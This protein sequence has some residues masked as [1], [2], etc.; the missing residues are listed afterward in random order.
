MTSTACCR[1]LYFI[2]SERNKNIIDVLGILPRIIIFSLLVRRKIIL[3]SVYSG[4]NETSK[5]PIEDFYFVFKFN[6]RP[7]H[8]YT[9]RYQKCITNVLIMMWISNFYT[10]Y[11]SDGENRKSCIAF[12]VWSSHFAFCNRLNEYCTLWVFLALFEY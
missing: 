9:K 8:Y 11:S 1:P 12:L 7:I 10:V 6:K 5:T 2:D 3:N 4:L